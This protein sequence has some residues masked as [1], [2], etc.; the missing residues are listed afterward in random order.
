M[1]K[2]KVVIFLFHRDLR[3]EDNVPLQNALDFA[4]DQ[5][6]KVLPMFVFTP[7][8]VGKKAVVKSVA[9]V[10]CLIQSVVELDETLQSKFKS[11]LCI[12]YDDTIKALE[13]IKKVYDIIG[14]FET[15]DYTPFAKQRENEIEKFCKK[16][17][18]EFQ[19]Y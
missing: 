11:N 15:K 3:L 7:A 6:A 13:K 4:K 9:S 5:N 12:L 1:S 14:L 19:P 18:M 17:G 16:Y 8:Q 2:N 10:A